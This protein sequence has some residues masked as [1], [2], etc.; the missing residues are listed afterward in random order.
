MRM[1][2]GTG[3]TAWRRGSALGALIALIVA[4]LAV[5]PLAPAQAATGNRVDLRV[6]VFTSGDPSTAAIVTALGREGVPYTTVNLSDAGRATIDAAFLA[7]ESPTA[8]EGKFQA[9]VLPNAAGGGAVGLTAAERDALAAYERGYSVRQVD[10]YDWPGSVGP[11]PAS[12]SG[13]LDGSPL[14]VTPSG[15]SGPFSYLTGSLAVDNFDPSVTE[16]Y[17]YPVAASPALP[18]GS[19]FTPL[20]NA[21]AG[22]ASGAVAGVYSHDS[23]EELVI[24]ANFNDGQQWFN[25]ISHGLITWMTRGVH[26]GYQRNYFAVQV[27]DIF[28]PDSRWSATGHCTPGDGCA[29]PTVTTPD[30]RMTPTDVANLV[31]WQNA[32]G[33]KLDMVFNGG[34]SDLWKA[35]QNPPATVDPTLDAFTAAGTENQFT[36]INHTYTHEFLGCIQVAPTVAGQTWHCATPTDTGPYFDADLV[37]AKETLVNGIRWMSQAEIDEPDPAEPGLGHGASPDQLRPDPAGHRRALRP[38]DLAAAARRQPVPGRCARR[39]PA[40][41]T[42]HPTPRGNPPRG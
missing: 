25:E 29:D 41:P 35:D 30:I 20:L 13:P 37:P 12:Y 21:A 3:P 15:L 38:E 14:T 17:G 8:R 24:T 18:A 28:L 23:R 5:L 42:P 34:G 33:F 16:V 11:L 32:N 36:W 26:L 22:G 1:H 40:S 39:L 19:T 10:S 31:A 2:M 9:I 4:M 7:N 27:D 6:L